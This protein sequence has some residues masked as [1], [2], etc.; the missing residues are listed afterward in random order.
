MNRKLSALYCILALLGLN[1]WLSAR[2]FR[3]EFTPFMYSIE[4]AYIALAR[5]FKANWAHP[6]WFPLWYGGIPI[7]NAYPPLLHH[8][9]A[10]FSLATGASAVRSV[11]VVTAF[12]YCVAPVTMFWFVLRLTR[13]QWQAFAAGW[14]YSLVS[15][16]L[17]IVPWVRYNLTVWSP[18]RLYS[19][20]TRD[21]A[22]NIAGI[23]LLLAALAAIHAALDAPAGGRTVFAVL[24]SAAVA[25]TNWL[26]AVAM[27]CGCLAL[28]VARKREEHGKSGLGRVVLI[29]ALAYA[30]AAP[31]IPPSDVATVQRNGQVL[32][33]FPMRGAQ[34]ACLAGWIALAF[35]IGLLLKKKTRAPEGVR[36]A[37][38][39]LF[40]MGAP[41]VI[42]A[43]LR[44]YPLPQPNRYVLEMDAA[45]AIAAGMVLGSRRLC[46]RYMWSRVM[47]G[48][49]LACLAVVLAPR[50]RR[51]IRAWLP[52][53]DITKTVEY[54]QADYMNTHYPGQ[55]VFVDGST[56]FWFSAFANNPE[57]GGSVD[58]ARSNPAIA[59]LFFAIPHLTGHVPDVVA[60]LKACG[61]RAIAVGGAHTRDSYRDFQAPGEFAGI[62]PEVWRDRDDAIYE[63][64]GSGSLAHVVRADTIVRTAP[65]DYPALERYAAAVD[66][67]PDTRLV[68]NGPNDATVDVHLITP[69]V[70]SVQ[71]S[72]DPGWR[73]TANG[74]VIRTQKDA[75]GFLLL[76]PE[77]SGSCKVELTY[78]GGT[79]RRVMDSLCICGISVCAWL[80]YRRRRKD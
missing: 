66:A 56:R 50:W 47:A 24:A 40:L 55:R 54:E 23:A 16:S 26:A 19:L 71:I 80:V 73:A 9:T 8:L 18:V 35:A 31:W 21:E 39:F 58:Q 79:Q 68:W 37:I 74:A 62:L 27:V 78:D 53:V 33:G 48:A 64:P 65:L 44:I 52:R 1:V 30:V 10:F 2:V 72:Y 14:I 67:D 63:I 49:A 60:L 13:S 32:G 59:S 57:L 25:L 43:Y 7:E 11:H 36:F 61:V 76:E 75:L 45:F 3:T 4:G 51:E 17:F 28:L 15:L 42:Y 69:Q 5:W 46:S 34:Y 70:V 77:C 20:L 12:F 22:A 6:G 41:P 38:V 29:G